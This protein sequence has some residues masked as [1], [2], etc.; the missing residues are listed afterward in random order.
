M[1]TTM[2]QWISLLCMLLM[3]AQFQKFQKHQALKSV[4]VHVAKQLGQSPVPNAFQSL[5]PCESV[6]LWLEVT[7]ALQ[8]CSQVFLIIVG[9]EAFKLNSNIFVWHSHILFTCEQFG[10]STVANFRTS[11]CHCRMLRRSLW[12]VNGWHVSKSLVGVNM[13]TAKLFTCVLDNYWI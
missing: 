5:H 10:A 2:F 6:N 3:L 4:L 9:F 11:P 1:A 12:F 8:S 13:H 7:C